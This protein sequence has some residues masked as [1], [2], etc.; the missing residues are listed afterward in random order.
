MGAGSF[1]GPVRAGDFPGLTLTVGLDS[2]LSWLLEPEA[3][4][5]EAGWGS[6]GHGGAGVRGGFAG[7]RAGSPPPHFPA[8]W[9]ALGVG[10]AAGCSRHVSAS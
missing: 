4:R 7:G 1:I 6:G 10:W 9:E 3:T 5:S 8:C 2:P